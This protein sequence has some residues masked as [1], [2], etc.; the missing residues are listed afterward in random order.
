MAKVNKSLNEMTTDAVKYLMREHTPKKMSQGYLSKVSGISQATIC[1][2]L[3]NERGWSLDVLEKIAVGL[4]VAPEDII[5]LG[6]ELQKRPNAFPWPS[7]LVGTPP[8]S[9]ERL[10]VIIR[11]TAGPNS[12]LARLI[13]PESIQRIYPDEYA[14]YVSGELGDGDMFDLV[15]KSLSYVVNETGIKEGDEEL[16]DILLG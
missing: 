15:K 4:G 9:N 5:I 13:V 2:N 10:A 12:H 14:K 16:A 7:K 3:K 6:R 8:G 1:M 11:F